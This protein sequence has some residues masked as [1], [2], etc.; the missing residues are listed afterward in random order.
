MAAAAIAGKPAAV[1]YRVMPSVAFTDPEVA[2]YGLTEKQA[3]EKGLNVKSTKFPLAGNGR[4][5][6][7]HQTEGFLRLVATKEDHVIVGAQM[8][9]VGASDVMAEAG[10]AIEAGMN[11]EDITLTIHGHPSLGEIMMDTAEGVLGQAIHM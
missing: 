1:D 2:S 11:A 3:K 6:S 8:V 10:L 4:A 7:L 5:L 9:G